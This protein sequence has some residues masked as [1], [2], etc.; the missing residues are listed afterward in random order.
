MFSVIAGKYEDNNEANYKYSC[1]FETLDEA[2]AAYDFVSDYPW[3]YIKYKGRVLELWRKD[4][5]QFN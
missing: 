3:A 5:H 2:I 1:E 4:T